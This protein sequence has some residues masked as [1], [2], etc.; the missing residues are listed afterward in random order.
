M[1]GLLSI[2]LVILHK[3]T[4]SGLEGAKAHTVPKAQTSTKT[5]SWS[6]K[7]GLEVALQAG[8]H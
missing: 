5:P 8:P 2:Q 4:K 3:K 7:I 1:T 6:Q